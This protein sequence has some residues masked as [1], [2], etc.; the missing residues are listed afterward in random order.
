M[1]KN[2]VK[3]GAVFLLCLLM[4]IPSVH[5]FAQTKTDVDRLL[6]KYKLVWQDEFD[7]GQIDTAK[8]SYRGDGTKRNFAFVDGEKTVSFDDKG[9]AVIKVVQENGKYYVGQLSTDGHYNPKYGY[10]E[11]RAKMNKGIGP[12]VAF[13]LQSPTISKSPINNTRENGAEIDIFEYHRKEP[14]IVWQ[15]IHINGYGKDHQQN[16][17]KIPLPAIDTG[18]HTFGLLWTK[19]SYCFYIDGK[20]T[21]ETSYGIS[22]R[23]Q[24]IIL[25]TELTGFG[26]EPSL[27]N[28][29][30]SVVFD[31][32]RVY[33]PR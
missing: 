24:F 33:Q 29:P 27:G 17:R 10:Y 6:E 23:S 31:Y 11:C 9:H 28:Y 14:Q 21:W 7:K 19:D 5:L 32:V 25:S 3:F 12:H 8:W 30:D 22:N 13:W 15:T 16:G 2:H 1:K 20:K 4:C 18:F 26:G